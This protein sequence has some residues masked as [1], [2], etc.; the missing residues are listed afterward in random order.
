MA[1]DSKGHGS[2][3]KSAVSQAFGNHPKW[4]AMTSGQRSSFSR[5]MNKALDAHIEGERMRLGTGPRSGK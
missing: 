3:G 1:K 5:K 2:N 4:Q